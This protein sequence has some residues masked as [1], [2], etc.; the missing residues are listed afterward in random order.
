MREEFFA[1]CKTTFKEWAVSACSSY[2]YGDKLLL[3]VLCRVFHRHAFLVCYDK[4]WTTLNSPDKKLSEM[5]LLDACNVHL[6]FLRPGI[7]AELILKKKYQISKTPSPNESPPEFPQWTMN[8]QNKS[9]DLNKKL[10]DSALLKLYLNIQDSGMTS[11]SEHETADNMELTT[12]D[13]KV[14]NEPANQDTSSDLSDNDNQSTQELLLELPS[15][16]LCLKAQCIQ[17][18]MEQAVI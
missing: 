12:A 6:I 2:Y 17:K 7:F 18:M 13:V 1:T 8:N 9:T 11:V 5:E 14:G 16:P 10:A 3:Y 15:N 4:I